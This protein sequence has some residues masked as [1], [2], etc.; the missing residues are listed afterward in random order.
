MNEKRKTSL[1]LKFDAEQA[2][3]IRLWAKAKKIDLNDLDGI[4]VI[5]AELVEGCL[6]LWRDRISRPASQVDKAVGS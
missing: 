4:S 1:T 5:V 2:M 6:E 3:S